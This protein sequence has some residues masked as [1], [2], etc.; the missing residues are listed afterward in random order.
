MG[1]AKRLV[2]ARRWCKNNNIDVVE[3]G[4]S[5]TIYDDSQ[6]VLATWYPNTDKWKFVN[7]DEFYGSVGKLE[8]LRQLG[9]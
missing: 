8:C 5:F 1:R 2:T 9:K 6:F 7:G 4:S 3:S